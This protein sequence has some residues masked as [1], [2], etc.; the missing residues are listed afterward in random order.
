[1]V[2]GK[3]LKI[4]SDTQWLFSLGFDCLVCIVTGSRLDDWSFIS[5][6]GRNFVLCSHIQ[7]GCPL[8]TYSFSPG[9]KMARV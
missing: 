8:D 3:Q 6:K 1:M 4:N 2:D 9:L 7:I 5:S